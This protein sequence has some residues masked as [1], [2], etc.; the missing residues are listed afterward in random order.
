MIIITKN[1]NHD[2]TNFVISTSNRQTYQEF[3]F[4]RKTP[5]QPKLS[6]IT[7]NNLKTTQRWSQKSKYREEPT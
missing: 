6:Q 7:H 2:L 5:I 1:I 4:G 3:Y